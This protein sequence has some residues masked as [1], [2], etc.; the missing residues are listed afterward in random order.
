MRRNGRWSERVSERERERVKESS[1]VGGNE[2]GDIRL[3]GGLGKFELLVQNAKN[4]C[5][6]RIKLALKS[7][8][9]HI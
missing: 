2:F 5:C 1:L 4:T 3:V 8:Q 6:V 7:K 9:T